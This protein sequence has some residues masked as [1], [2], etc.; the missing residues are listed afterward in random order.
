MKI[1]KIEAGF[2]AVDG[3]AAFGVVPKRVWQKRYPCDENN[4]CKMAMRCLLVE[5]DNRLILI[6][7]GTGTKQLEYLK[8]YKFSD[9]VD[10]E[11]ALN[12]LGYTCADITDVVQ[13]HLHFDHCGGG[14]YYADKEKTDIR[15]TF[16]NA[17]FWVGKR[18]WENFLQPNV[19]EADSYFAEN[20]LPIATWNKLKL[21]E[22]D[23]KLCDE[24]ELRLFDGH[25]AGQIAAYI[26]YRGRTVIFV[27]DV[28]PYAANLPIAWVS[29]YDCYPVTSMD[30]KTRLLDEAA[31][32]AQI[33]V[34]QHDAY[35][36]CATVTK[37][38]GRV[39]IKKTLTVADL[40]TI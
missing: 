14:T 22:H 39:R 6:D 12:A 28:I 23:I 2:F 7:T 35:T 11:T 3:G 16:P 40:A 8:Y 13:T 37:I 1:N 4:F 17:V 26:N 31:E 25:T 5:T 15:P 34:F 32:Q 18:Q 19:R 9:I 33:L 10:F 24:V 38:N 20:M 27:G 30:D 29:A 21:V 36:E